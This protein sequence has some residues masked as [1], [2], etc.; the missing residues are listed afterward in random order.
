MQLF[1]NCEPLIALRNIDYDFGN[2]PKLV[3][4]QDF[5]TYCW[6]VTIARLLPKPGQDIQDDDCLRWNAISERVGEGFQIMGRD[7][8]VPPFNRRTRGRGSFMHGLSAFAFFS[9]FSG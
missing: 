5:Q 2:I 8:L 1:G 4:S 3:S 9:V 6:S 7:K